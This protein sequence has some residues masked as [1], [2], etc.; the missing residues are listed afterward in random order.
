MSPAQI[1]ELLTF[2]GGYGVPEPDQATLDAWHHAL[3]QIDYDDAFGAIVDHYR[4]SPAQVTT[5][6]IWNRCRVPEA[7][8]PAPAQPARRDPGRWHQMWRDALAEGGAAC[9]SR[10]ALVLGY[11]P[12]EGSDEPPLA[13]RLC[14]PPL[15]YAHPAQWN[16]YVP[17]EIWNGE[18][19]DSP[20]RR[21]LLAIVDEALAL[22]AGEGR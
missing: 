6:D 4:E 3:H 7:P 12:P 11:K 9:E 8:A 16:G 22:Q 13:M 1:A 20:R 19:N 21:A 14:D 15:S 18:R 2:A 10:R 17:P 5:A